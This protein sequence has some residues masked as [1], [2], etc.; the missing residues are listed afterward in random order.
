MYCRNCGNEMA[1]GA[2]VCARC[3]VPTGSGCDYC[4][5]CGNKTDPRAVVC[6]RCGVQFGQPGV[7][8]GYPQKSKLAAGLFGLFL[9]GWGVHNF[10]LGFTSK[11]VIQIVLTCLTCGIAALWGFIEGILILSGSMN[12]DANGVPLKE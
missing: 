4:Y 11:G 5:N 12:T 9:G 2:Y 10:Y 6:V 1:P 8:I 7:P 3:G